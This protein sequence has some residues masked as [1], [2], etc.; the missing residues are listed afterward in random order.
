MKDPFSDEF[1]SYDDPFAEGFDA[2][3]STETGGPADTFKIVLW[4]LFGIAAVTSTCC[5][6]L[7]LLAIGEETPARDVLAILPLTLSPLAA[8]GIGFGLLHFAPRFAVP[9]WGIAVAIVLVSLAMGLIGFG[10]TV[11]LGYTEPNL[12]IP[13]LTDAAI[14]CFTPAACLL[15][16]A[17]PIYFF[18]LIQ[19]RVL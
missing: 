4:V 15:L 12:M 17:V 11:A 6:L 13:Q 2:A 19:K 14:V 7:V 1:E 10:G 9:R 3:E 18:P 8:A 5:S 16:L